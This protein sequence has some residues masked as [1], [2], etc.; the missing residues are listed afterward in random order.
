MTAVAARRPATPA[1]SARPAL[2]VLVEC[3]HCKVP[4][5]EVRDRA[6]KPVR[7]DADTAGQ[8]V[9]HPAGE[10]WAA[11]LNEQWCVV[12]PQPG[13]DP[14]S[15]GGGVRYT[16]HRCGGAD[17]E[18]TLRVGLG[19]VT[20]EAAVE[21][22]EQV[23]QV[24]LHPADVDPTAVRRPAGRGQGLTGSECPERRLLVQLQEGSPRVRMCIRCGRV[25]ARD[26]GDDLPW[27]GGLLPVERERGAAGA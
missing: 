17:A 2:R 1:G 15:S 21:Q 24:L 18:R 4:L 3:E 23:E 25:T 16:E 8:A 11:K 9:R 20:V 10:W 12:K 7:F 14:P 13:E 27:C 6:G 22:G 19:T 5:T 26:D